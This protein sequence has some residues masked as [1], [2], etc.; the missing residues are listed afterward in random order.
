MQL[1]FESKSESQTKSF[2]ARLAKKLKPSDV[3]CLSG[4]LGSGKTT[5]TKGMARAL[6]IDPVHL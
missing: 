3:V 4:P 1:R 2:G 5:L 6:K